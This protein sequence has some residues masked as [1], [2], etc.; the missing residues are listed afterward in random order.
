VL[1]KDMGCI[2]QDEDVSRRPAVRSKLICTI[3][4]SSRDVDVLCK[5]LEAGMKI[6]RFDFTWGTLEYHTESVQNLR[7]AMQQ[8]KKSCAILLDTA[9][10]QIVVINRP[11]E[12]IVLEQGQ[13]VTVTCDKSAQASSSVLPI[14]TVQSFEGLAP[15]SSIFVGQYLFTGSETT[16]AYLTV[17]QVN[18]TSCTCLCNNSCTLEGVQLTVQVAGAHTLRHSFPPLS[19]SDIQ[20]ITTWGKENQVDFV[21]VAS[22]RRAADV[23]AC[24]DVL[25]KAGMTGVQVMAKVS[26][27]EGL[28]NIYNI[29]EAADAIIFARGTLG[30]CVDAEKVF[31]AQKML[32]RACNLAGKPVYVT[33][34]V[35]TMTEAPRPTRAEATDVANLI[36][37]G[38]DGILLGSETFRGKY[39]AA[40]VETVAYIAR[41]AEDCF[42]ARAFYQHLMNVYGCYTLVPNMTKQ[43]ALA[44][45]AVRAAGKMDAG[46]IVVF[47]VTGR[48]ARM[49]SK[50]KPSQPILAVVCSDAS[51]ATF[52][53]VGEQPQP[54][55]ASTEG[56]QL[57][58]QGNMVYRQCLSYRGVIPIM[59]DPSLTDSSDILQYALAYAQ[60]TGLVSMGDRVVVSQCPR[61]NTSEVMEEAGVVALVQVEGQASVSP[62][63]PTRPAVVERIPQL[64]A[65]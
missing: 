14:S 19:D 30:V 35:D 25:A 51:S 13:T 23:Q 16:S 39:P 43:E 26:N 21:S 65:A 1:P 29:I 40:T 10:S 32:L 53:K 28:R 59:A 52:S 24:R 49:V 17:Q 31:L 2:L 41:Q 18:G 34:V 54:R 37:D 47:T 57:S 7:T 15:G 11:A 62:P 22:T 61:S 9:G 44:S 27:P 58:W 5:M 4:S 56:L 33:R 12:G 46:L 63:P 50:Y 20:A 45:S 48:T 55:R 6:A 64:V 3:G 42:D 60:S 38:A 36:L 8:T